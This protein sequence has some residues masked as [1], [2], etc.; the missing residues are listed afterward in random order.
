MLLPH[1]LWKK[2]KLQWPQHTGQD[3]SPQH[4]HD[5]R[6][7]EGVLTCCPHILHDKGAG[8]TGLDLPE[9][10][11]ES[12]A[13]LSIVTAYQPHMGVDD[14]FIPLWAHLHLGGCSSTVRSGLEGQH[15]GIEQ[16]LLPVEAEL[17]CQRFSVCLL[18]PNNT[19]RINKVIEKAPSIIRRHQKT[20]NKHVIHYPFMDNGPPSPTHTGQTAEHHFNRHQ[21]EA[22]HL[23]LTPDSIGQKTAGGPQDLGAESTGNCSLPLVESLQVSSNFSCGRRQGRVLVSSKSRGVSFKGNL[24]T[25]GVSSMTVRVTGDLR[26]WGRKCV[27]AT[28]ST[29]ST[30][31]PPPNCLIAVCFSACTSK[32]GRYSPLSVNS[33]LFTDP[34]ALFLL[35]KCAFKLLVINGLLFG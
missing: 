21:N 33:S 23:V 19:N 12:A 1:K 24:T 35:F 32:L 22:G 10:A 29:N 9:A 8:E 25:W 31:L 3:Q 27:S 11:G 2:R 4:C 5:M 7:A 17:V 18:W 34:D 26:T 13:G 15:K 6:N 28:N 16:T 20:V 30:H 14:T